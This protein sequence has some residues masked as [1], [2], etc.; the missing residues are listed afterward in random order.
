MPRRKPPSPVRKQYSADLQRRVIHQPK[1][2]TEI[3]IDLDMPVRVVQ[4]VKQTWHEIGDVCRD[5]KDQGR[6]RLLSFDHCEAC[7]FYCLHSLI[8]LPTFISTKIQE[9]LFIQHDLRV[10]MATISRTMKR[11]G[12]SSVKLSRQ[13]AERWVDFRRDFGL[14]IGDEPAGRIVCA[15]EA[16]VNI[17]TTYR[18]NAW[19]MKGIRAW[20]RCRGVR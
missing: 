11:L 2:S 14:E 15:D 20:K 4:R 10:S 13:A 16:A 18:R 19:Y 3:A 1:N 5:R 12:L 9:Q 7:L 6:G 8:I 17:L